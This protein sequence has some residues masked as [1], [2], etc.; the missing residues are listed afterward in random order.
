MTFPEKPTTKDLSS[1]PENQDFPGYGSSM[2]GSNLIT[3]KNEHFAGQ[4]SD[5]EATHD[6]IAGRLTDFGDVQHT[7]VLPGPSAESHVNTDEKGSG[8][9]PAAHV[10]KEL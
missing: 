2:S 4:G 5:S 9:S 1:L 7:P 6:I 3:A 10:W 8:Y